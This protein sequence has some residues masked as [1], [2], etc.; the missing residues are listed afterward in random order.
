MSR[1]AILVTSVIAFSSGAFITPQEKI[2]EHHK[3]V[4]SP[5]AVPAPVL[6]TT[7]TKGSLNYIDAGSSCSSTIRSGFG[8]TLGECVVRDNEGSGV[9]YSNCYKSGSAVKFTFTECE[10][11]YCKQGMIKYNY[12]FYLFH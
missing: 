11:E 7:V 6:N 10:D 8:F 4:E 3:L 12:Q 1:S 2:Q 9:I 5:D